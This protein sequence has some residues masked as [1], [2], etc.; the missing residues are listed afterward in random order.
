MQDRNHLSDVQPTNSV[1]LIENGLIEI[2]MLQLLDENGHE[3][4]KEQSPNID[5]AT[6]KR[7]A[8]TMQYIRLLDER[9]VGAQR[10]GRISFYLACTGE[11]ASTVASA[12]ALSPD[13]MILSQ[14]REQGA[15]AY[16]GHTHEQFL[17]PMLSYWY[18]HNK[19]PQ[20]DYH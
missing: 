14:Y 7:I 17:K 20:I 8:A 5:Q 10:Q 12:A 9:M 11:E 4:N 16:R 15:L 2:P 6:A 18:I 13:E 3:T 1:S 19:V